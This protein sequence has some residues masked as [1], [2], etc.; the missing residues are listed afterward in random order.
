M[1]SE[2]RSAESKCGAWSDN[3]TLHTPLSTLFFTPIYKDY[4]WGG[5]RIPAAY[6]REG[7]PG[8]CAESWEIAAHPDG[9]TPVSPGGRASPRADVPPSFAGRTLSSLAAEYGAALTGTRAP[10][11]TRFPL[12]FKLIDAREKLSVQ[13]HPSDTT[14]ALTGGEPK[15]EMWYVLAHTERAALYA[16]LREGVTPETLRAALAD[17]TAE[18]CLA[19]MPVTA[20]Q[21]LFIPGGLVHAIG[22]GCLIYEVQQN[23]NTTYRL[24]DWDRTGADGQPRPLHIEESFNVIDWALPPPRLTTASSPAHGAYAELAA[25]AHFTVRKLTL[26]GTLTVPLD[27]T[28]FHAL[29][30]ESGAAT[31]ETGGEPRTLPTGASCLIPAAAPRYT[32]TG[33]ASILVTTL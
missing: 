33:D 27:G 8:R 13:V 17:G 12:L 4:I 21:A 25:C 6:S 32:L 1:K 7:A 14:A 3:S 9:D 30:I 24:Y 16:G 29:F 20:G 26:N 18:Q 19:E 28:T 23:S 2:V 10:C 15:T 31:I 11:P 5:S 22:A